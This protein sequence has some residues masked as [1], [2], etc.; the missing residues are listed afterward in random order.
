MK[1]YILLLIILG[2][3]L[4]QTFAQDTKKGKSQPVSL[5]FDSGYLIDQQTTFIPDAKTLEFSIQ[6][7][8]GSIQNGKS[9]MWGIY[10]PGANVRLGLDYVPI[11][12][13][14]VGAGITKTNMYT[15]LTAKWTIWQQTEDNSMP[16]A[17]GLFGSVAIDGRSS[18]NIADEV[19]HYS[20]NNMLKSRV[21][22]SDRMA[23][24]S[25]LIIGRKFCE[26]FSLQAGASF[27]HFNLVGKTYDHDII[28]AHVNGR[29]K[30]SPESSIIF[31]Y[32]V[33]LKI[34]DISEQTSWDTHAKPN[35]AIGV[36]ISTFT[37]SFQ[38]YLESANGILPQENMIF[39]QNKLNK[40]GI[41]I[42]FTITR[43]WM[44]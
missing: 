35:L 25:Q 32:D 3:T 21:A 29:I 8:F 16:I 11:K 36:D 12:N 15:D 43:L 28:G 37:H 6:H 34:K 17:V 19:F 41:A 30:F 23:Y 20:G 14:Q 5:P 44:F 40:K 18:V 2:I 1:K 27:T 13:L 42:G 10:S 9:D 33:P 22:F 39:N 4:N 38:I 24:F 31:N 7:K 26:W